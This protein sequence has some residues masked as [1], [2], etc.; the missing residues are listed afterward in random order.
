MKGLEVL[1]VINDSCIAQDIVDA[2]AV[3]SSSMV[4]SIILLIVHKFKILLFTKLFKL[5]SVLICSSITAKTYDLGIKVAS[6]DG[7]AINCA[8]KAIQLLE[9]LGGS[10]LLIFG[11]CINTNKVGVIIYSNGYDSILKVRSSEWVFQSAILDLLL[12]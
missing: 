10:L 6:D 1:N 7:P 8:Y 5:Q 11:R 9:K 3:V 2:T 12:Y 4:K